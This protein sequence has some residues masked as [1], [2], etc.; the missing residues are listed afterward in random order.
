VREFGVGVRAIGIPAGKIMGDAIL[1]AD[2]F[3]PSTQYVNM[4]PFPL[5]FISP[6][7]THVKPLSRNTIAVCSG[8]WIFQFS[9]V[10]SIRDAT[11]TKIHMIY[12]KMKN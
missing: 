10:E 4:M 2:S 3:L 6:R 12:F 7:G 1:L 9:P 8:T 11:F 5:T